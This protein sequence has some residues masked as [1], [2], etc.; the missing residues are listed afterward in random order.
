MQSDPTNSDHESL[1]AIPARGG[2]A[3]RSTPS[4]GKRR[5]GD[6]ANPP[7]SGD[8]ASLQA[9]P[10]LLR[11]AAQRADWYV[12]GCLAAHQLTARQFFVLDDVA[13]NHGESQM[14]LGEH[15]GIDRSTLVSIIDRLQDNGYV[16]RKRSPFDRRAVALQLTA[17]GTEL[18]E[19]T[20]PLVAAV[21]DHILAQL[22]TEHRA[23]FVTSLLRIIAS[24]R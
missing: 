24:S 13:K 23:P 9:L 8:E 4:R 6:K 21:S 5:A 15:T 12:D 2:T 22:A 18:L 14:A 7:G 11:R 20:R 1:E 16:V 17:R 10:H 3:R 19:V